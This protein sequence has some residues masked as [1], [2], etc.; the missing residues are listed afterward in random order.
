MLFRLADHVLNR[1]LLLLPEKLAIVTEVL[2]GRIG[3]EAAGV[4]F[5]PRD[6]QA[7]A[8]LDALLPSATRFVGE[9]VDRDAD[10]RAVKGLPYRRTPEGVA[11]ITIT[12]SLVNRGAWV[13]ASS[14]LTSYEGIA[15]QIE[16]A[17]RDPKVKSIILDIES[18]GGE[19]VGAFETAAL[20]R[21]ANEAKP[22][23]ACVNGMAASA[24]YAIASGAK[25]IMT[26]ETGLAGSIGVVMMHA[27]FSRAVDRAGITP[28]FIHAG[29]HKVDGHAYAPLSSEVKGDLQAEVDKFYDLFTKTV[30]EGRGKRLSAKAARATEARTFIGAAAKDAGLVDEVGSFADLLGSLSSNAGRSRGSNKRIV[31]MFTQEDLDV[32]RATGHNA[33]FADGKKAGL[34]LGVE[35][36]S[37]AARAEGHAA[38]VLEGNAAGATAERA[39]I[40]AILNSDEAKG[41]EALANHF[42]FATA[43]TPD[44]V[45]AALKAA[46]AAAA[47]PSVPSIAERHA[48]TA[49]RR[50]ATGAAPDA[51]KQAGALPAESVAALVNAE[52]DRGRGAVRRR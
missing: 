50:A 52:F 40:A 28:T 27:D 20:V 2:S 32:A 17:A 22:V 3:V 14:G 49:L 26:T 36:G 6:R 15:F 46:P 13:G 34:A 47:Q 44:K 35:E 38:G 12:G 16:S 43:D 23:F 31:S 1:P 5:G 41:R 18:P 8:A 7:S 24:A 30:A 37:R 11:I 45:I 19:A 21:K 33:G 9:N 29:A 25:A 4:E 39:R 42:A 48:E 51:P 10:G